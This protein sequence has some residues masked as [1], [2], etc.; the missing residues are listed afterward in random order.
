MYTHVI[1]D[2]SYTVASYANKMDMVP[3]ALRFG[4]LLIVFFLILPSLVD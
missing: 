4:F 3:P 1:E 2:G